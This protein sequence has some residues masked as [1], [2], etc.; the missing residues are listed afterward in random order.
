MSKRIATMA[1]PIASSLS[2]QTPGTL[3]DRRA[4]IC[5]P[6]MAPTEGINALWVPSASAPGGS[7]EHHRG[8][9][10]NGHHEVGCGGGDMERKGQNLG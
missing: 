9:G 3:W 6:M 2:I 8:K 4:P 1:R 5:A 10:G 7:V